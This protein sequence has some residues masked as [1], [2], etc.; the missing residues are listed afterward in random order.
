ML[1]DEFYTHSVKLAKIIRERDAGDH[2]TQN[3][4]TNVSNDPGRSSNTTQRQT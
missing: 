1:I 4:E 3:I 2:F